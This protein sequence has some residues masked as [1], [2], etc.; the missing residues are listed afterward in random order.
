MYTL[1]R[2]PLTLLGLAIR[3][4]LSIARSALRLLQPSSAGGEEQ[5]VA[6]V[7]PA[8]PGPRP[9][10]AAPPPVD[11][12]AA[13]RRTRERERARA[14]APAAAPA[15]SPPAPEAERLGERPAH[16]SREAA[17]VASFGPAGDAQASLS[18]QAPW[19]GYELQPAPDIIAR[20]RGADEATK[21]VVLLYEQQHKRRTTVLK[22]ARA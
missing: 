3:D 22:A 14:T 12:G 13:L 9:D 17:P 18:V 8:R 20:V 21:A 11:A 16:V 1:L 4:S 2:L 7:A 6:P 15:A 10:P 5:R 19:K